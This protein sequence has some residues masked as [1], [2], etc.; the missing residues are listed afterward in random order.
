MIDDNG[1]PSNPDDDVELS[2][3]QIKGS[4]GR[5]D[6]FCTAVVAAIA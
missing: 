1:T 6:D 4:T 2:F 3:E 5:T